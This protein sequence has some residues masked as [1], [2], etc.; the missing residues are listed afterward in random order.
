MI[1]NL[2]TYGKI[3][4]YKKIYLEIHNR[5]KS[6]K[7]LINHYSQKKIQIIIPRLNKFRMTFGC[8]G[9]IALVIAPFLTVFAILPLK[10]G[11]K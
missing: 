9:A 5:F 8:L 7:Y 6:N 4:Y 11:L 1:F 2:E 10:W 3:P